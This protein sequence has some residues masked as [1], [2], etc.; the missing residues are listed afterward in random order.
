M[1]N[2]L[3][4]FGSVN[5]PPTFAPDADPL[6]RDITPSSN[7]RTD[8]ATLG[9]GYSREKVIMVRGT[10]IKGPISNLNGYNDLRS[11]VDA[12]RAQLD[13]GPQ[14][15]YFWDDRYY[16][17][18]IARNVDPQYESKRYESIAHVD[19]EFVTGDPF[20]YYHSETLD[21]WAA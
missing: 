14:N 6:A 12:L 7:P 3:M 4:R 15:L 18:V 21:V 1:P 5:L 10:L 9:V 2:R 16:R 17:D 20:K 8:G 13:D 19:I 11:A